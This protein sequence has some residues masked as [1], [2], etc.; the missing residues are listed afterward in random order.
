MGDSNI[1]KGYIVCVSGDFLQNAGIVGLCELLK[2][3]EAVKETDYIIESDRLF[4]SK[5][6]LTGWDLTQTYFDYAVET[7]YK[8]TNYAKA[9]EAIGKIELMISNTENKEDKTFIKK[10]NE[11]FK[12]VQ[13]KLTAASLKSGYK[14]LEDAGSK[15]DIP[16]L[17]DA[18]K[19]SKD[20]EEKAKVLPQIREELNNALVKETLCFKSIIY[21]RINMFWENKA[22]LFRANSNK[23]MKELFRNEFE[24]PL[25]EFLETDT[26]KAKDVCISCGAPVTANQKTSIAFMTDMADDLSRKKSSF[27][28]F[29][30]DAF[31][32]PLCTM[33]YALVPLG[34]V[35]L[36]A[37]SIFINT[38][39]SI[40]DLLM[41]NNKN[42]MEIKEEAEAK[43]N[44]NNMKWGKIYNRMLSS[45]IGESQR[46]IS[47]VQVITRKKYEKRYNLNIVGK[48]VL[49]IFQA[50]SK[51]FEN[52]IKWH[53]IKDRNEYINVYDLAV[54][55]LLNHRNQ[56]L[57]INHILKLSIDNN[58][59]AS[60]AVNLIKI[61]AKQSRK[62]DD[63]LN[64]GQYGAIKAGNILRS[65]LKRKTK[66]DIDKQTRGLV[67]QLLNALQ[68]GDQHRFADMLLRI[69]TSNNLKAPALFANMFNSE[70][71]F[72]DIGYAFVTGLKGAYDRG[73]EVEDAKVEEVIGEVI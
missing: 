60:C 69:Y 50:C 29:K 61:Q 57:L 39:N 10:V 3:E 44:T 43:E 56:Y 58:R 72:L 33:L 73:E 49:N 64:K 28:N 23:D 47:N 34:F 31:L 4:I 54:A 17:I 16:M 32:C 42:S 14:I 51:S 6:F 11:Q 1:E 70:N 27:W 2:Y 21:N 24:K 68:V 62:G 36:G 38:N 18:M 40:E 52:L 46:K 8:E 65:E 48:D 26:S 45:Q 9:L 66:F 53:A 55:N 12:A 59:L 35:P 25:K 30:P 20:I 19:S 67:Y 37:D 5:K 7:F 41:M 15:C 13:D 71:D 22:F 63:I